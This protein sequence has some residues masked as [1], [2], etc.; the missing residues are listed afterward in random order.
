MTQF[1]FETVAVANIERRTIISAVI[2]L[3]LLTGAL[4]FGAG[5]WHKGSELV[6]IRLMVP[7]EAFMGEGGPSCNR[8][9][10]STLVSLGSENPELPEGYDGLLIEMGGP[11]IVCLTCFKRVLEVTGDIITIDTLDTD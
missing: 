11:K 6:E 4:G 7:E 1:D 2:L 10:G 9:G 3:L 5:T 8:C